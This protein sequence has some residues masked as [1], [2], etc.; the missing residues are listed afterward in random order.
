MSKKAR[1][2]SPKDVRRLTKTIAKTHDG[3]IPAGSV[4][5]V[6]Q[7]YVDSKAAKVNTDNKK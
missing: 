3:K 2:F 5:A 4:A 7:H 6:A 1:P